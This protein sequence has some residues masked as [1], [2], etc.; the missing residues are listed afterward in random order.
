MW[1]GAVDEK[2]KQLAQRLSGVDVNLEKSELDQEVALNSAISNMHKKA[3][4]EQMKTTEAGTT[5]FSKTAVLF[6]EEMQDAMAHQQKATQDKEYMEE[7]ALKEIERGKGSTQYLQNDIGK[8]AERL[9]E[10]NARLG[11][12]LKTAEGSVDGMKL[13]AEG[14]SDANLKTDQ[15]YD[16]LEVELHGFMLPQSLLQQASKSSAGPVHGQK[17]LAESLDQ[18]DSPEE[19]QMGSD[20]QTHQED[21]SSDYVNRLSDTEIFQRILSFR[22]FKSQLMESN[23]KLE[24]QNAELEQLVSPTAN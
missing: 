11:V 16:N 8:N 6:G 3:A 23:K 1:R 18:Q 13:E 22:K 21:D 4:Y 17:A 20:S 24:K 15:R 10:Q 2:L 9:A 19:F 7:A 12:V 14:N 5:A